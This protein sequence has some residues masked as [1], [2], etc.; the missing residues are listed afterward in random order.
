MSFLEFCLWF[1]LSGPTHEDSE[2]WMF[3][4]LI[5]LTITLTWKEMILGAPQTNAT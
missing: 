4:S 5:Y 1:D 2:L 3:R